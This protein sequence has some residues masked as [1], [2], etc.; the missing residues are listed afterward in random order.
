KSEITEKHPDPSTR[1]DGTDPNMDPDQ[2]I[3]RNTLEADAR[4]MSR[5]AETESD[6]FWKHQR[7]WKESVKVGEMIISDGPLMEA[8]HDEPKKEK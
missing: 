3:N 6:V 5:H 2:H 7:G 1:A 4:D 8:V